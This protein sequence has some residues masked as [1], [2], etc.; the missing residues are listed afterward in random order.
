MFQVSPGRRCFAAVVKPVFYSF[1]ER[2]FRKGVDL[3]QL[4]RSLGFDQR[5]TLADLKR[6]SNSDNNIW[7]RAQ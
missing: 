5:L 7:R 3:A 2:N 6:D 1:R 4:S